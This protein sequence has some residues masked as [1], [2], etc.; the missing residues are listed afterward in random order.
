[1]APMATPKIIVAAGE[2][3]VV[4]LSNHTCA[5]QLARMLRDVQRTAQAND[6]SSGVRRRRAR[7]ALPEN[8][9]G[10]ASPLGAH[11]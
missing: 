1:M 4:E 9:G 2:D 11:C 10:S 5:G 8:T 7:P 3:S 6:Q